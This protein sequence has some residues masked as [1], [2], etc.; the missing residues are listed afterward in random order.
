MNMS[1][2]SI[3]STTPTKYWWLFALVLMIFGEGCADL[4]VYGPRDDFSEL[5]NDFISES[6]KRN[7]RAGQPFGDKGM[8]SDAHAQFEALA[9]DLQRIERDFNSANAFCT[10]QAD[11]LECRAVRRWTIVWPKPTRDSDGVLRTERIQAVEADI[12]YRI[13]TRINQPSVNVLIEYA[14][15]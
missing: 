15:R 10:R 5:P 9:F 12:I 2:R 4:S 7:L 8:A 6:V 14:T 1:K 11:A 13:V 3:S